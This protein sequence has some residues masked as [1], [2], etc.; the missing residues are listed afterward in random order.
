[1]NEPTDAQIKAVA[2]AIRAEI[3][4]LLADYAGSFLFIMDEAEGKS[5]DERIVAQVKYVA[6]EWLR[7]TW[8][9]NASAT[10]ER[11][12]GVAREAIMAYL[13]AKT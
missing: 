1:M 11:L 8:T 3:D 7:E 9:A 12:E 4:V 2:A 5:L 10:E 13:G 6:T